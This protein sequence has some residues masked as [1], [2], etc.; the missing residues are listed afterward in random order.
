MPARWPPCTKHDGRHLSVWGQC[1]QW[2]ASV[3]VK[4]GTCPEC[5]QDVAFSRDLASGRVTVLEAGSDA[6][7]LHPAPLV[8]TVEPAIDEGALASAFV[9]AARAARAERRAASAPPARQDRRPEEEDGTERVG[10]QTVT[11]W[12]DD[13]SS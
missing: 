4:I 12:T 9:R 2:G 8:V 1:V 11:V 10:L 6:R 7:H 5:S 13:G 3:A